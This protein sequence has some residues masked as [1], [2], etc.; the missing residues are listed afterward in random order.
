[1]KF[2]KPS[3]NKKVF[4]GID[5]SPGVLTLQEHDGSAGPEEY[6]DFPSVALECYAVVL[7]LRG[8]R[9]VPIFLGEFILSLAPSIENYSSRII[10]SKETKA[11]NIE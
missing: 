3:F 6:Y 8:M 2:E 11:G 9:S 5:K 4:K 1:M 7:G 10:A